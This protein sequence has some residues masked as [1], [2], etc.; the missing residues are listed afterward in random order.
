MCT[1]SMLQFYI[2]LQGTHHD[3]QLWLI[4]ALSLS[5]PIPPGGD[6]LDNLCNAPRNP[7]QDSLDGGEM[8]C[9]LILSSMAT[10]SLGDFRNGSV[11]CR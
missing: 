9:P 2:Y 4:L 8:A 11:L 10:N 6:C 3:A 7:F 5:G 1:N